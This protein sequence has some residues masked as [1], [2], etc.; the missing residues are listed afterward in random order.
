[1]TNPLPDD[2][3]KA[4]RRVVSALR[5][6]DIAVVDAGDVTTGKDYLLKVWSLAISCPIGIAIVHEGIRPETMANI[7]YEL[8]WMQAYGR[9]TVVIRVGDVKLPSDLV[10]TEYIPLDGDFNRR[11]KAFLKSLSDRA[12]Y[13]LVLADQ[14]EK[15]PLL[16]IDYLRRTYLLT[17]SKVL[18]QRARDIFQNAG[19]A[20]RS[21][22]SVE[23]MMATF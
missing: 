19:L 16:A 17:G 7:F 5:R 10:R 2:L 3:F 21:R 15:N 23:R 18:R 11:F 9:E 8:G 20:S 13:Y 22:D 4:R 14:L 1:M 12:E 6:R